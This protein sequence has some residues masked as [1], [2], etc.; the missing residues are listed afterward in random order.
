[1]NSAKLILQGFIGLI[2]TWHGPMMYNVRDVFISE[3]L[4]RYGEWAR[5]EIEDT[6]QYATGTVIDAGAYIGTHT[7]SYAKVA[8]RV[9]SFEPQPFSFNMLCGNVALNCHQNVVPIRAAIGDR[10]SDSIP[11]E[12]INYESVDNFS[13]AE[14]GRGKGMTQM[15]TLDS[16]DINDISLI[17]MDIE[18][19]E[20]KALLGARETIARRRPVIYLEYE[21]EKSKPAIRKLLDELEYTYIEHNA[22]LFRE[23]NYAKACE[24]VFPGIFSHNLLCIPREKNSE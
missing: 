13:G 20:Y 24:N 19:Y 17:K 9:I 21:R 11:M 8:K 14:V 18:G 10:W 5:K 6:L 16:L 7:L 15:V 12:H 1:M 22:P 3:C 23:E 2:N 4:E